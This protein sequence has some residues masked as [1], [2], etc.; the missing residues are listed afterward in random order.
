MIASPIERDQ[1]NRSDE[2][3]IYLGNQMIE[4]STDVPND[5]HHEDNQIAL[6]SALE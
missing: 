2:E 3:R 1:V 6:S 5:L 4:L